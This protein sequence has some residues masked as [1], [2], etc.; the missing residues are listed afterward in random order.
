MTNDFKLQKEVQGAINS[1]PL[2]KTE[3]ITVTAK[4]R[5]ITL[6]G[7][8][9]SISKKIETEELVKNVHGVESVI[10][11]ISILSIFNN[12]SVDNQLISEHTD[13]T[14]N[15]LESPIENVKVKVEVGESILEGELQWHDKDSINTG[16][17]PFS[18]KRKPQN[19]GIS[20]DSIDEKAK[21]EI[22]YELV[23]NW[24]ID[25]DKV[26][27]HVLKNKVTLTGTVP[28]MYQRNE[29]G[30]IAYK[31]KGVCAVENELIISS[32]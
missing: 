23:R 32:K 5:V 3:K 6:S 17:N 15:N 8:V 24:S 19:D 9:D 18:F 14:E 13:V 2:L 27:V 22:K 28:S 26:H 12:K 7:V 25:E 4:D 1:H 11:N 16:S 30:R 20:S 29:I 21:D 10:G 31:T